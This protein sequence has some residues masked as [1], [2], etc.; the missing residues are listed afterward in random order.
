PATTHRG[1][2]VGATRGRDENHLYVIAETSDVAEARDLLDAVL[3]R[4]RADVPAVSQRRHL[5]HHDH[6]ASL[7]RPEAS[8]ILPDW[9][10]PW[11]QALEQRRDELLDGLA[12]QAD[13]RA[14]A[15]AELRELQSALVAARA[16]WAP[17][18]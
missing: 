1:L 6:T 2:Y 12:V 17:Y 10:N 3:A 9:I 13:L 5:A 11:R 7:R 4:D 8:S 14:H 18:G 15:A 16:S